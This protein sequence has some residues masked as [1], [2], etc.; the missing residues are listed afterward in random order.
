MLQCSGSRR[1]RF[2]GQLMNTNVSSRQIQWLPVKLQ[3]C[4]R[5]ACP[6]FHGSVGQVGHAQRSSRR[7]IPQSIT[8]SQRPNMSLQ[9]LQHALT[10]LLSQGLLLLLPLLVF[11]CERLS[12]YEHLV[13]LPSDLPLPQ[14][15]CSIPISTSLPAMLQA[16]SSDSPAQQKPM[17]PKNDQTHCPLS[18]LPPELRKCI[19]SYATSQSEAKKKPR[20]ESELPLDNSNQLTYLE[21][22]S[23]NHTDH[24]S[25]PVVNLNQISDVKPSNALLGT[26]Q[27]VYEEDR[28][29][30]IVSQH[31]FLKS[32]ALTF[33]IRDDSTDGVSAAQGILARFHSR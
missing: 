31:K 7:R 33:D 21:D 8:R 18:K 23:S 27:R 29:M 5:S 15:D 17:M 25:L 3:T 4:S 22:P 16:F 19:Y 20:V 1:T 12:I 24:Q 26:C 13:S 28:A 2:V 14:L 30:F 10:S 32:H 9:G 11:R 6:S